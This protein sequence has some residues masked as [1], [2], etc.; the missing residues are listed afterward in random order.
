MSTTV[1]E[2]PERRTWLATASLTGGAGVLSTAVPFVASM[3]PSERAKAIGAPVEVDLHGLAPGELRTV[4]WRGQPV[5]VLRRS[6]AMLEALA[7]HDEWLADPQSRRSA[8]PEFA[9]NAGRSARPE[10][11]VLVGIC[12]HLGCIP[13]FRPTPGAR[14]IGPAWPGG[15]FCPCHGSKFDLAGRVFKNVP[16][17]TNLTV[18]PYG[19]VG[20]S[21]LLIGSE[22]VA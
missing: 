15:F 6:G 12:T 22:A 10:L 5:F 9:R 13:T 3:A 7:G 18:P 14:D 8:Q 1:P 21:R 2:D 11:G 19:F 4:E 17:P 16:A 20:P